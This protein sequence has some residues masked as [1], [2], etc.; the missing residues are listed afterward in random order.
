MSDARGWLLA[1]LLLAPAAAAQDLAE[2]QQ[3][4]SEA[5]RRT[6]LAN[7]AFK[8]LGNEKRTYDGAVRDGE[9]VVSF[10]TGEISARDTAA[11]ARGL[12]RANATLRARYGEAG[13]ALTAGGVW[14]VD[15]YARFDRT[16]L[17][18]VQFQRADDWQNRQVMRSP[19]DPAEVEGMV[20]ARVGDRLVATTPS[21]THYGAWA[22]FQPDDRLYAEV[23]RRLA[24]S[25]AG[26]GRRCASGAIGACATVLTPF[27]AAAEPTRYFDA[28]DFRF[29][30][31]SARLPALGD[32][33]YFAARRQCVDG[34]DSVCAVII[35]QVPLPDPFNSSVRG[36]LLTHAIELGGNDAVRRAAESRALP[37]LEALAQIAGV[38]SDSLLA[39]WHARVYDALAEERATTDFPLLFSSVAWGGLFLLVATR[40]RFL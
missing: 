3:R 6:A 8:N 37:P 10:V 12:A 36:T 14:T 17:D 30:V 20:L 31:A 11:I 27:D 34:K 33:S 7:E 4:Y 15:Q 35:G 40:R 22:A 26:V 1:L 23:A 24:T 38:S 28:S 25:W 29:V 32:S 5:Q 19:I 9:L 2:W 13:L 16:V 21:L 18:R 39:S